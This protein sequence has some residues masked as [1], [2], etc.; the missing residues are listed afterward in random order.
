MGQEASS[1]VATH[2]LPPPPPAHRFFHCDSSLRS[3]RSMP[4]RSGSEKSPTVGGSLMAA[5]RAYARSSKVGQCKTAR[6][7]DHGLPGQWQVAAQ[8]QSHTPRA[9]PAAA[10]QDGAPA[11][12]RVR[13]STVHPTPAP[14]PPRRLPSAAQAAHQTPPRPAGRGGAKVSLVS[15]EVYRAIL[16]RAA[17]RPPALPGPPSRL[18]THQVCVLLNHVSHAHLLA[19]QRRGRA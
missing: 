10:M 4:S 11:R 18:N 6:C 2:A 9:T 8:Q 19:A 12:E 15:R 14:Q 13:G 1:R 17:A 5:P 3:M 16:L 7:V